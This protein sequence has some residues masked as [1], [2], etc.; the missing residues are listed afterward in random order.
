VRRNII[1]LDEMRAAALW[2]FSPNHCRLEQA[3]G[4]LFEVVHWTQ[5]L[6][7]AVQIGEQ[8]G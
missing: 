1:A 2:R 4:S 5:G 7:E 3:T 6:E 8:E